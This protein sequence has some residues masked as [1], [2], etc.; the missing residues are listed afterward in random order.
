MDITNGHAARMRFSRFKQFQEGEP[1]K[2]R[3]PR[4]E[5]SQRKRRSDER[6][7]EEK[8]EAAEI[9]REI[10]KLKSDNEGIKKEK[11]VPAPLDGI[12]GGKKVKKEETGLVIPETYDAT[13]EGKKVK[14]EPGLMLETVVKPEV[15][16]YVKPA[17]LFIKPEPIVKIEFKDDARF[18][19][20][21]L[22]SPESS[23]VAPDVMEPAAVRCGGSVWIKPEKHDY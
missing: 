14:A 22:S 4:A 6:E 16:L 9:K 18:G 5:S 11:T 1:P 21:S 2:P 15:L 10:K 19:D 20:V 17:E 13:C 12:P 7:K 23:S 3:K 8:K